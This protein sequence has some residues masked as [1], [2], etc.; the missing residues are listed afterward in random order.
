MASL[1]LRATP[2]NRTL[3][4][5]VCTPRTN[6][7]GVTVTV[8]RTRKSITWLGSAPI[9]MLK[10]VQGVSLQLQR[11]PERRSNDRDN[12]GIVPYQPP[13]SFTPEQVRG[14]ADALL[15]V[16]RHIVGEGEP[17]EIDGLYSAE[18]L[19]QLRS[20]LSSTRKAIDMVNGALARHWEERLAGIEYL[21]ETG[22]LWYVGRTKKRSIVDSDLFML[23]L[24]SLS[25]EQLSKLFNANRL[26]SVVKVTGM[27][28]AERDTHVQ[29]EYSPSSGVSIQ[30][31]EL[32]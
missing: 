13:V 17:M 12:F 22:K 19:V 5:G 9:S 11:Y 27:T 8:S 26:A 25:G 32:K 23:W 24:S 15:E 29:E 6:A 1:T 28:P 20:H 16:A 3:G 18:E 10:A 2:T 21:D 4:L 30:S 31:K 7:L 14:E